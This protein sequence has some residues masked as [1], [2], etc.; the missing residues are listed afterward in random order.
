[1]ER[2]PVSVLLP[3]TT[4]TPACRQVAEQLRDDGVP[5]T[6]RNYEDMI[7]GFASQLDSIDR[8]SEAVDAIGDDLHEAFGLA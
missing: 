5:V 4:W 1:M 7:H 6:Y 8:A 2:P 3:T